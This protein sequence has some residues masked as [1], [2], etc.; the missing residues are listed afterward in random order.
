M[1]P[2]GATLTAGLVAGLLDILDPIVFYGLRGV[3]PIRILQSVAAGLLGP[4]AFAGG[5]PTAGLGLALHLFIAT[6]VAAVFV[7]A[8]RRTPLLRARPIG[9]GAVYGLG[10]FAVMN[11]VVVPLSAAAPARWTTD[12]VVNLVFAHVC[13][14]GIPI[15]LIARR[16]RT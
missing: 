4:D 12:V 2:L 10:V 14:V 8:A 15:A 5:W 13:L 3:A 7:A 1:T 16:V 6:V 11:W 9:S